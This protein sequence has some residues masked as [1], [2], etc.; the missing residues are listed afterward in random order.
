MRAKNN[1]SKNI[2][3]IKS[4]NKKQY[5]QEQQEPKR[6]AIRVGALGA[7]APYARSENTLVMVAV[8]WR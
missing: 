2:R 8:Q 3:N 6:K 4:E 1:K 7:R 5:Q